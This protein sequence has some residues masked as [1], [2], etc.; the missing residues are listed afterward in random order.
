MAYIKW[1]QSGTLLEKYEYEKSLPIRRNR[2]KTEKSGRQKRTSNATRSYQAFRRAQRG[3]RRIVRSNLGG[4]EPPALLTVTMR[5][6]LPFKA[7][8]RLFTS[9]IAAL[10]RKEGKQFR[11]IAV[12]EF[13]KRGAVHFHVLIWGL[14]HYACEG[15]FS[16]QKRGKKWHRVFVCDSWKTKGCECTSRYCARLW[17]R[18]FTD[19]F[20]TDG[21]PALAGYLS[22]YMSKAMQD[23]RLGGEKAYYSSRNSLRPVSIAADSLAKFKI[24][25]IQQEVIHT[26]EKLNEREF[27]TMWLGRCTYTRYDIT[28]KVHESN[29]HEQTGNNG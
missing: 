18:G 21:H 13:Q 12:P 27:D 11:Y 14:N 16:R 7:S 28:E 20:V 26:G 25:I 2:R 6:V 23:V 22:K 1:V 29:N 10:R 17:L 15:H 19:F 5:Q 4:S 9:F 8:V 3:F 24:E